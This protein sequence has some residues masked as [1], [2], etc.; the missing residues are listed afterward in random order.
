MEVGEMLKCLSYV[1]ERSENLRGASEDLLEEQTHLLTHTSHL[2][3]RLTFF[4]Y[5]E[6][7]QKM[8]N[9]PG[10]NLVLSEGFLPMVKRLD[11]CLGY[12]GQHVSGS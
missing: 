6:T 10:N 7:A 4:S 11:E 9:N 12:L 8:L 1:E 2:A 5:L 3:H